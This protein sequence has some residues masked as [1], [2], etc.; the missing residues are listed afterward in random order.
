[1]DI[2][3]FAKRIQKYLE[4]VPL[5]ILGS[6]ATI[7]Y[8]LPSMQDLSD[9]ILSNINSED[10][11]WISFKAKLRGGIDLET[12]LNQVNLSQDLIKQIIFNTWKLIN[13]K[14][15]KCFRTIL[16][17]TNG[18]QLLLSRLLHSHPKEVV[19]VTTNYDRAVEYCAD[20][21]GAFIITGFWGTYIGNFKFPYSPFKGNE[22]TIELI[23][24]HGS[25]DWFMNE[26]DIPFV[27]NS[28]L[29]EIPEDWIPLI[30]TP[31][32]YKYQETHK[33]PYRTLISRSDE[34]INKAFCY[35]CIGYGFNDDHI[36]PKLLQEIK[37]GKPI[38]VV[39]KKLTGN[40]E[41][42]IKENAK[43][44]IVIEEGT[45]L[46]KSMIS[47]SELGNDEVEYNLW[48]LTNFV[49]IWLGI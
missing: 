44:F 45:D 36:Q 23:K 20:K 10:K 30:V 17:H 49:K 43:K 29:D 39:T 48:E 37:N 9:F 35:L 41:A 14:D 28:H 1:M 42:I 15:K 40:G 26:E 24:V 8:G 3:Q 47:S 19:I 16:E 27:L 34:Q 31:G 46:S 18:I 22:K 2:D 38:V 12:A 6:G 7:P 33:D 11:E 32:Y 21:I 25:I 13:N 4:K 5:I